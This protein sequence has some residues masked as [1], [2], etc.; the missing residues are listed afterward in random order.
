MIDSTTKQQPQKRA[1]AILAFLRNYKDPR[2]GICTPS[3]KEIAEAVG[4]S[5][6]RVSKITSKLVKTGHLEKSPGWEYSLDGYN[7]IFTTDRSEA[8]SYDQMAEGGADFTRGP[9][10]YRVLALLLF[11]VLLPSVSVT[12][13]ASVEEALC[14][15]SAIA[16]LLAHLAKLFF[17]RRPGSRLAG[18]L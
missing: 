3:V 6:S 14:Y 16:L 9:N 15:K 4:L 13:S 10:L 8:K 2:W 12:A 18:F 11:V 7:F 1:Q 17:H 5:E